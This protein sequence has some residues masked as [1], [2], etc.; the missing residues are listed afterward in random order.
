M[1]RFEK[2]ES[3]EPSGGPQLTG[4]ESV[5]AMANQYPQRKEIINPEKFEEP[6][7]DSD[8]IASAVVEYT[9]CNLDSP[10]GY[11]QAIMTS[12]VERQHPEIKAYQSPAKEGFER[13]QFEEW[14]RNIVNLDARTAIERYGRGDTFN[15]LKKLHNYLASGQDASTQAELLRQCFDGDDAGFDVAF[16]HLRYDRHSDAGWSYY[17]SRD[18]SLGMEER[19]NADGRLYLNAEPMDT[20]DIA[21]KFVKACQK[22]GLPYEFKINRDPSRADAM[23]FYID[24]DDISGYVE[25][26]SGILGENPVLSQRT[27]VPPLLTKKVSDKIGYG[28][29]SGGASY[30]ERQCEKFKNTIEAV[31]NSY[32]GQIISG[33]TQE[34]ARFLY[35]NHHER[36]LQVLQSRLQHT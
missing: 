28:D 18:V 33:T 12:G 26:L 35:A 21:D 30:S 9:H 34:R 36:F 17:S 27:G 11:Y 32:R 3:R 23:V 25:I 7:E 31:T 6:S 20:Y 10:S 19:I 1:N 2:H 24:N 16:D 13:A 8:T 29:E 22:T 15:A 5:A 14:K 4:W